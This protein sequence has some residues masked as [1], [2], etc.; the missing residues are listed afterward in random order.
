MS[1]TSITI[2][3][4]I[5]LINVGGIGDEILFSPVIDTIRKACPEAHITLILER[6]SQVVAD[7][8]PQVDAIAPIDLQDKSRWHV[9]K[10]LLTLLQH[11]PAVDDP[12]FGQHPSVAAP[13]IGDARPT[14]DAVIASGSSPFIAPLLGLSTIPIRIGFDSGPLSR[15]VLSEAAPLNK[16]VYAADMYFALAQAFLHVLARIDPPNRVK[17]L[18]MGQKAP[19]PK[20]TADE[21][22]VKD[23]KQRMALSSN[24]WRVM[25]HPGVSQVSVA[26][27]ILKA[28]PETQ[29]VDLI[30]QLLDWDDRVDV[31][32]LGGP[33]DEA[34][35]EA[36]RSQLAYRQLDYNP[37]IQ[38][39]YGETKSFKELAALLT[40]ANVLV[41]VDSAPMHLA[42]GLGVPVVALFGPTNEKKLLPEGGQDAKFR[43]VVRPEL[44]CRPCLWEHRHASCHIPL[45]LA[46][47]VQAVVKQVQTIL[48]SSTSSGKSKVASAKAD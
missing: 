28:W 21:A 42:V 38:D 8:L 36:I 23:L 19:R 13:I 25:I 40:Q 48:L 5:A 4:R 46:I 17:Y 29:W 34:T 20:L 18:E 32:L 12:T 31:M 9:A 14:Y 10:Q 27:N 47:P 1:E 44:S 30:E 2:P 45:C 24:R 33:D 26:K 6:R 37:R 39:R 15:W 43:A 11:G 7:C 41:S 35:I 22:T 16:T 3:K